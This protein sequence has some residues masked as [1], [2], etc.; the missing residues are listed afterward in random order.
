MNHVNIVFLDQNTGIR[1]NIL[2][3]NFSNI[4]IVTLVIY[5]FKL[6]HQLTRDW[7]HVSIA[8][9]EGMEKTRANFFTSPPKTHFINY[10]L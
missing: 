9:S 1:N 5:G 10:N 7:N 3:G 4:W 6:P 8:D 2:M